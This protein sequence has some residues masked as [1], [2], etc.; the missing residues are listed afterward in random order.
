MN[1]LFVFTMGI[2]IMNIIT[3]FSAIIG[4]KLIFPYYKKIKVENWY[5]MYPCL[6]YQIYW[7]SV[8]FK[9]ITM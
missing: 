6:F 1:Y 7:W 5:F 2:T 3:A 8:Y 4:N 9:L